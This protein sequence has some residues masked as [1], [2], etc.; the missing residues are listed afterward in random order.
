MAYPY[1]QDE[2]DEAELLISEYAGEIKCE[3]VPPKRTGNK[4]IYGI[5]VYISDIY[6]GQKSCFIVNR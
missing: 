5:R 1:E 4:N 6:L 2:I 3:I